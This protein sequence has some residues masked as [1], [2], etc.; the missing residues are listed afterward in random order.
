MEQS[1]DRRVMR[2]KDVIR[3]ALTELIDE[4]GFEALTVKD[5][6]TRAEI[7]RGTFYLHYRDKY[8]LLEQSEQELI[9]GLIKILSTIDLF[10]MNNLVDIKQTFPY[11]VTVFEYMGEHADFLKTILGPKG[12]PSFH[13]LLKAM[14]WEHLFEK[15]VI[16]FIKKENVLVP[17]EYLVAYIASAH[18][19]I[20]EEWLMKGRKE[21]P[22]EIASI[23]F[24]LSAH[25]PL[26][27]AGVIKEKPTCSES[28]KP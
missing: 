5:I 23:M 8:D 20:I 28:D 22:Q 7:N 16:P 10:D 13:S 2:T 27:A 11:I 14:M 4:K 12:D 19:G 1:K 15:N 26:Y 24:K 18:F 17:T 25:G 21:S 6:T 3:K 9:E